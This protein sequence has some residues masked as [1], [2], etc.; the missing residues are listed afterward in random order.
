MPAKPASVEH[1]T[2]QVVLTANVLI[3]RSFAACLFSPVAKIQLPK[4]VFFKIKCKTKVIPIS[5]NK[6]ILII[7]ILPTNQSVSQPLGKDGGKPPQIPIAILRAINNIPNVVMNDGI[8][9]NNVTMAFTKP[10]EAADSKPR[11]TAQY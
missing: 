7:S 2:K 1:K 6:D 10:R 11:V 8:L 4:F 9:K 5:Q 3:P